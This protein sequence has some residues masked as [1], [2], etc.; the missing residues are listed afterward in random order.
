MVIRFWHRNEAT[1]KPVEDSKFP[2]MEKAR[3]EKSNLEMVLNCFFDMREVVHSEFVPPCQTVKQ[4]FYLKIL[5]RLHNSAWRDLI[6]GRQ[7]IGFS[8]HHNTTEHT[9]L[10]VRQFLTKMIWSFCS[11][12]RIHPTW[13]LWHFY[14]PEWKKE[15][16]QGRRFVDIGELKKNKRRRRC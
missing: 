7:V 16:L 6:Y 5:K 4:A 8:H 12:S 13:P 15:N 11:I 2:S 1:I 14:F 3:Q 10:S 9:A